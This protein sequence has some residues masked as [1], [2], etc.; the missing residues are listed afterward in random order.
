MYK[1]RLL[2][3]FPPKITDNPITY[4][5]IRKYDIIV[6]IL[7]AKIF[8]EEEGQLIVEIQSKS[9]TNLA[10]GIDY[11]KSEG[12]KVTELKESIKLDEEICINCGACTGVC[13]TGALTLNQETWELEVNQ[14]EC[15]LCEMCISVCP[16]NALALDY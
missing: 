3:N 14:E 12:V 10:E 7:Q 15:L 5:L 13:K 8:Q 4:Q 1:K 2:L 11:L 6:N 9:E 16:V